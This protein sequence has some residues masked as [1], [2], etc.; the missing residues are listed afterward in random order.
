MVFDPAAKRNTL[1]EVE[2]APDPAAVEPGYRG[3]VIAL[4]ALIP[5]FV[6]LMNLY[7]TVPGAFT[8]PIEDLFAAQYLGQVVEIEPKS[9]DKPAKLVKVV[10]GTQLV[11]LLSTVPSLRIHFA[12]LVQARLTAEAQSQEYQ[13]ALANYREAIQQ[14]QAARK[15][16]ENRLIAAAKPFDLAKFAAPMELSV[17]EPKVTRYV[18]PQVSPPPAVRVNSSHHAPRLKAPG[19][20]DWSL[21]Q[22]ETEWNGEHI[23]LC[24][25]SPTHWEVISDNVGY[26]ESSDDGTKTAS[27]ESA[28]QAWRN[29]LIIRGRQPSVSTP[30]QFRAGE[31][32]K[33]ARGE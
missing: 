23:V 7:T 14:M 32:E 26:V 28:N 19:T 33:A 9:R 17:E 4:E 25:I 6:T 29:F 22:Y 21:D 31:A 12:D 11:G 3:P 13:L 8:M 15:A 1:W 5:Q 27:G 30:R 10:G 18:P 16:L 20:A 24:K 2:Q